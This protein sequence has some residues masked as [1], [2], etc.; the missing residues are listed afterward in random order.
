MRTETIRFVREVYRTGNMASAARNLNITPQ[1]LGKAIQKLEEELGVRLFVRSAEGAAPT[2]ICEQ[3]FDRL[4]EI[5]ETENSI[6]AIISQTVSDNIEEEVFMVNITTLGMFIEEGI[7]EYN[8]RYKDN[9]R[10]L[11]ITLKD[12]MQDQLFYSNKYA[13]RYISKEAI[14]NSSLLKGEIVDLKYVLITGN[15]PLLNKPVV[16]YE[17]L[18]EQTLLVEDLEAPHIQVLMKHFDER[19][20]KRPDL[21]I[22]TYVKEV[23]RKRL[24]ENPGFVY[25]A[26][27]RDKDVIR[28]YHILEFDPPYSTTMCLETHRKTMN[29]ELLKILRNKLKNYND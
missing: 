22:G 18:S 1:G 2:P 25:F 14:P 8:S 24:D 4:T 12:E 3:I 16:T 17:D 23:I 26:R 29:K 5:V 21:K 15:N 27:A 20:L 28:S 19:G 7:R 11:E 10:I 9:I 6:R 13:Y